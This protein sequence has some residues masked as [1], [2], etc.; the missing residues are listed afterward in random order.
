VKRLRI[1]L[2]NVAQLAGGGHDTPVGAEDH[3]RCTAGKD[4]QPAPGPGGLRPAKVE[5]ARPAPA[6]VLAGPARASAPVLDR[7]REVTATV[8]EKAAGQL[9]V[10]IS[11]F[12]TRTAPMTI[13]LPLLP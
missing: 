2:A 13:S 5:Y 12:R 1:G 6:G 4:F 7:K 10:A 3:H 9:A 11:K 8:S